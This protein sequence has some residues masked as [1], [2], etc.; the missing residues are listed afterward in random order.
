MKALILVRW[1][2]HHWIVVRVDDDQNGTIVAGPADKQ[3]CQDVIDGTS[4][5]ALSWQI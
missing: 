4:H 5:M 2:T 3:T 1:G